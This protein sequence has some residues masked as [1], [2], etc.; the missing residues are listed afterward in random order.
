VVAD[1]A[2]RARFTLDGN[3]KA[4]FAYCDFN[5]SNDSLRYATNASGSWVSEVFEPDGENV[6]PGGI[7]VKDNGAVHIGGI[8]IGSG[9]KILHYTNDDISIERAIPYAVSVP[10]L[11]AVGAN[12]F[13]SASR[14]QYRVSKQG[15]ILLSI[16]DIQ[17]RMVHELVRGSS[18]KGVYRVGWNGTDH[19]NRLLSNGT[20][21]VRFEAG[22]RVFSA[23]INLLK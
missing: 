8:K 11:S 7:V 4:H 20:Y 5:T 13:N 9:A 16:Y 6:Q 3:G 10:A 2:W 22:S 12:P 17:G 23:K 14:L 15:T 19:N 18:D 21:I 1:T